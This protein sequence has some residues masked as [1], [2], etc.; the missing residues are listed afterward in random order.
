[1]I[2]FRTQTTVQI[3]GT[4]NAWSLESDD[5]NE[6][7]TETLVNLEI[8]GSNR[9]GYNLVMSPDGF[10]T[11]DYWYETLDE[12]FEAGFDLFSVS[13]EQWKEILKK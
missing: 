5:P 4:R 6:P 1:M 10:F 7:R 9:D 3:C 13:K 8:Q 11:A 2:I 12:A